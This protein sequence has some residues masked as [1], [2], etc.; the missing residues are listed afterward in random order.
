M[1][2]KYE[3]I[4]V[5]DSK[6]HGKGILAKKRFGA[7]EIVCEFTGEIIDEKECVQREKEGNV[8]IFWYDDIVYIDVSKD[9]T[10]KYLNH[11]CKPNCRIEAS[12]NDYHLLII[13]NEIINQNDEITIDYGYPEIYINC[14]CSYCKSKAKRQENQSTFF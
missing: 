14:L 8:Y 9:E 12:E 3:N 10:I 1:N 7:D 11:S 2:N 5:A 13:A 4:Y 6:I